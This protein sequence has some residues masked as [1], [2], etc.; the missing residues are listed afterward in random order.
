MFQPNTKEHHPQLRIGDR[1][2]SLNF[3]SQPD[4]IIV[5]RNAEMQISF[6]DE[7]AKK[8]VSHVTFRM[9]TSKDG[10]HILSEFFHSH[11]GEV[12]LSFKDTGKATYSWS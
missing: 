4:P 11:Q 5:S 1:E 12:R 9:D 6:V 10:K 3:D 8:K 7:N 2:I